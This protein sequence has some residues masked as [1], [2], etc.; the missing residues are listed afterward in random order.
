MQEDLLA[1]S[2]SRQNEDIFLLVPHLSCVF[3]LDSMPKLTA[4]ITSVPVVFLFFVTKFFKS[5]FRYSHSGSFVLGFVA[6]SFV[7]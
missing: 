5:N 1:S 7:S 6:C 4:G 3:G 2:M